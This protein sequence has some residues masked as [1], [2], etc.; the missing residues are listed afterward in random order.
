[1]GNQCV[2]GRLARSCEICEAW[3]DHAAACEQNERLRELLRGMVDLA[4]FWINREYT[5]ERAR[6]AWDKTE[7]EYR[8]WL[9]LGYESK[10]LRAAKAAL[11]PHSPPDH[12]ESPHS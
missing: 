2:H 4:E 9:A 3:N 8:T 5:G 1:M 7:G 6:G 10:A 12:P 11:N